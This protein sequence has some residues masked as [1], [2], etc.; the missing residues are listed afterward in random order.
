MD[1]RH[2]PNGGSL[3]LPTWA[4]WTSVLLSERESVCIYFSIP[5]SS[6]RS[7]YCRYWQ[8]ITSD[9]LLPS[10]LHLATNNIYNIIIFSYIFNFIYINRKI[11]F[12]HFILYSFLLIL[13]TFIISLLKILKWLEETAVPSNA[14]VLTSATLISL[15]RNK[16]SSAVL[17]DLPDAHIQSLQSWRDRERALWFMLIGTL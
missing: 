14:A 2:H 8:C 6:D 16:C 3:R 9:Y 13:I 11:I 10:W 7:P 17:A 4:S 5:V 1:G 12:S 15:L